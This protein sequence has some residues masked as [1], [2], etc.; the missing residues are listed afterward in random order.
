MVDRPIPGFKQ[1]CVSKK[2]VKSVG[3]G[4]CWASNDGLAYFGQAGPKV[5]TDGILTKYT[6]YPRCAP[7]VY[8]CIS[9][10]DMYSN[11]ASLLLTDAYGQPI[12]QPSNVQFFYILGSPHVMTF[13]YSNVDLAAQGTPPTGASQSESPV[14]QTFMFR[15][16][17]WYLKEWARTSVNALYQSDP[18]DS[19]CPLAGQV[20]TNTF[21]GVPNANRYTVT[22]VTMVPIKT[23]TASMFWA[24]LA[25]FGLT[26]DGTQYSS[27]TELVSTNNVNVSYPVYGPSLRYNVLLSISDFFTGGPGNDI[28][29][30]Y[31]PEINAPLLTVKGYNTYI[32][33]YN[34]NSVV[35]LG[36][37]AV[38][39]S[40]NAAALYP[41]DP[42]PTIEDLFGTCATWLDSWTYSIDTLLGFN[43]MLDPGI[44][45][46]DYTCYTNRGTYQSLLLNTVHGLPN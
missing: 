25:S 15:S 7:K 2:S 28:F 35:F 9:S 23:T 37:S 26:W 45:P 1:A 16:C 32:K 43:Q 13:S 24:N 22:G 38:P 40:S 44:F 42:R 27:S 36:T 39:L 12:V 6:R 21:G 19:T 30:V 10:Y 18:N 33:G 11:K 5:L 46:Y 17:Y 3:H 14:A 4:V 34:E 29:G 8:H 31:T 20:V 41:N